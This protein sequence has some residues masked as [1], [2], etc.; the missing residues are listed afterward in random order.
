[1]F[2]KRENKKR[3]K[4]LGERLDEQMVDYKAQYDTL[5][6]LAMSDEVAAYRI[7]S[8][9][10]ADID[11][12]AQKYLDAVVKNVDG[13][14]KLYAEWSF[15]D[16]GEKDFYSYVRKKR[17]TLFIKGNVEII[18]IV[19]AIVGLLACIAGMIVGATTD[20]L[21]AGLSTL[22]PGFVLATAGRA[23][24][25]IDNEFRIP[26]VNVELGKQYDKFYDVEEALGKLR[27]LLENIKGRLDYWSKSSRLSQEERSEYAKKLQEVLELEKELNAKLQ[28]NKNPNAYKEEAENE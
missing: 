21:A 23:A 27:E 26:V 19:S 16:E 24:M 9:L 8:K 18:G 7:G 15:D 12:T 10:V 13:F 3:I 25:E 1:M 11:G 22:I 17:P 5:H 4:N 20:S 14:E 28:A 6:Q 2:E